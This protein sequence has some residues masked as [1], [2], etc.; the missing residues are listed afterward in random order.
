M[1]DIELTLPMFSFDILCKIGSTLPLWDLFSVI[2]EDEF[3]IWFGNWIENLKKI[4]S[5]VWTV[6]YAIDKPLWDMFKRI[7]KLP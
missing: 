4:V 3:P 7:P 6:V 5:H 1:P 2:S